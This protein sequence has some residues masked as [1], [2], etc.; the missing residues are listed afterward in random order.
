MISNIPSK[1]NRQ[2]YSSAAKAIG[3]DNAF[4][5]QHLHNKEQIDAKDVYKDDPREKRLY[6]RFYSTN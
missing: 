1:S 3:D 6:L 5:Y 4:E 2:T